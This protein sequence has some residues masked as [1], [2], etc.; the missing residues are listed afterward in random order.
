M[1]QV[2]FSK[3]DTPGIEG[4]SSAKR[5][6]RCSLS[7][8]NV[9]AFAVTEA[10]DRGAILKSV[11]NVLDLNVPS[12]HHKVADH[13]RPIKCVEWDRKG[14]RLLICDEA[15]L[16][17]IFRMRD[18]FLDRWNLILRC[19]NPGERFLTVAW[20]HNGGTISIHA[21]ED[22]DCVAS[23][24]YELKYASEKFSP[25]VPCEDHRNCLEGC[26]LV[27]ATGVVSVII[28]IKGGYNLMK[29]RLSLSLCTIRQIDI[30]HGSSGTLLT[31]SSDGLPSSAV[32]ITRLS[33]ELRGS[34]FRLLR[35]PFKSFYPVFPADQRT[36]AR[37]THLRFLTKEVLRADFV[38]VALMVCVS[39]NECS[40]VELWE[41]KQGATHV[42]SVLGDAEPRLIPK[43]RVHATT[44]CDSLITAVAT[45]RRSLFRMAPYPCPIVVASEDQT[46]RCFSR[47][48]LTA[49][50]N[51]SILPAP[52]AD[53]I[54]KYAEMEMCLSNTGSILMIVNAYSRQISMFRM[55]LLPDLPTRFSNRVWYSTTLLE[56]CLVSGDDCLDVLL[57][58]PPDFIREVIEKLDTDFEIQPDRSRL[59]PSY[60][61]LKGH[62]FRTFDLRLEASCF[63]KMR[64]YL[65]SEHIRDLLKAT[66]KAVMPELEKIKNMVKNY[67]YRLDVCADQL[68][69]QDFC[70]N[71]AIL[72]SCQY[73]IQ[74]VNDL[75]LNFA[76][77]TPDHEHPGKTVAPFDFVLDVESIQEIR[78]LLVIFETCKRQNPACQ[79]R[80]MR[81]PADKDI[82]GWTF[83][84][85]SLALLL[86]QLQW[87]LE[88]IRDSA[89]LVGEHSEHLDVPMY[90]S[91]MTF[92]KI[93]C[94]GFCRPELF[95]RNSPVE[96]RYG[97]PADYVAGS[98][99]SLRS[100]DGYLP[101]LPPSMPTGIVFVG[102]IGVYVRRCTRCFRIGLIRRERC[103][104]TVLG[105]ESLW[106]ENCPC[107]GQWTRFPTNLLRDL[108]WDGILQ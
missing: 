61:A 19:D 96:V 75:A 60:Q 41:Y 70:L 43:W 13:D 22:D 33:L 93:S 57:N 64:L 94:E 72:V 26:V 86:H 25:S 31:A 108:N 85:M 80:Y 36:R 12:L 67:Q 74:W 32:N 39:D 1:E 34:R 3:P 101:V 106:T 66:R 45:Y 65:I 50:S 87:R 15:G 82:M 104:K 77:S 105:K 47:V 20:F 48:G 79:P 95:S 18:H 29:E 102:R 9:F 68:S 16:I 42:H 30:C 51:C 49:I 40:F 52:P 55:G 69:S 78:E 84:K 4:V 37:V 63:V 83:R 21:D 100:I 58:T 76:I 90:D 98:C 92:S 46:L 73:H 89:V 56:Y 97:A 107:G 28:L 14:T 71:E 99:I 88:V 24:H 54:S 10:D 35:Y 91:M 53:S 23:P 6:S 81:L 17:L 2:F 8:R 59:L 103:G 38:G 62:V 44:S 11:I 27:S 7:C 5:S